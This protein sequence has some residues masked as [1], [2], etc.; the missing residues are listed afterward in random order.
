MLEQPTYLSINILSN[1]LRNTLFNSLKKQQE[2]IKYTKVKLLKENHPDN[3]YNYLQKHF[4]L[5]NKEENEKFYKF[6]EWYE[7]SSKLK[8]KNIVPELYK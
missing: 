1:K 3:L 7:K 5:T 6:I 2:K 4:S 8:L